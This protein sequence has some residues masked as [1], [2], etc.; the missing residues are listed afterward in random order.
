[1]LGIDKCISLEI[2]KLPKLIY[3]PMPQRIAPEWDL[4]FRDWARQNVQRLN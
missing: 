4:S 3:N 2:G 1:M